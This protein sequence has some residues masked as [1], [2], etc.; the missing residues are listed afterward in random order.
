MRIPYSR[1]ITVIVIALTLSSCKKNFSVREGQDIFFK[2]EYVNYAWGFQHYGFMVDV[3][4]RVL[5]FNDPPKWNF[6]DNDHLISR[7]Q[8]QENISYCTESEKVIPQLQLSK[9][10]KYID[11]IASSKITAQKNIGA[12]KGTSTFVCYQFSENTSLYKE[13]IIKMEGD[14]NCENLNYFSK[15]VVEWMREIGKEYLIDPI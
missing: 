11:K 13:T 1:L 9:F 14:A 3:K 15:K 8:V 5:T 6:S 10:M 7:A 12:D 2:F 4:G